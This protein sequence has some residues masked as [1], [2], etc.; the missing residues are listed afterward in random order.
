MYDYHLWIV[1][2]EST[3]DPDLG[4]LGRKAER[5][6]DLVRER[7]V[8]KPGPDEC[9]LGVNGE[10]VFQCSGGANHRGEDHE[11]LL[12]VLRH[13]A[14]ELPGSYGLVYW[15][16]DENPGR[17]QFDGYRVIV[18]ARGRLQ[19][20]YDPFLSPIVPHVED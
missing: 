1:L 9:I 6:R 10:L 20:R 14:A 17:A 13:V 4:S 18:L 5:L 15:Y 7:L 3:E 19:D 11:S 12:V 2:R 16:D 8:G